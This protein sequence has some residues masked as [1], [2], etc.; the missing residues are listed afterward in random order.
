MMNKILSTKYSHA[1]LDLALLFLRITVG[2]LMAHHGYGKLMHFD[3][4]SGKFMEFM[5][6]SAG[7]S[8][9]LVVFSEFFCSLLLVIGLFTRLAL[10]PLIITM[11]VAAFKAHGGDV[12]GEGE[13]AF[14]YLS[15]YLA[16]LLKGAGKYSV[17]ALL[18]DK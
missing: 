4:Y 7:V 13:M 15:V 14:L 5:G 18:F 12:M 11:L 8:L 1:Q 6:L 3:E 10:L 16:L 9:G 2:V 17:D